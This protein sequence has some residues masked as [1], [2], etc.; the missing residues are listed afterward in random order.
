MFETP[1]RLRP[2]WFNGQLG[3][4]CYRRDPADGAFRLGA[5]NVLSLRD[6]LVTQL[7]SFIDP[8]LLPR[9]GLPADPP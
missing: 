6:G 7:S 4:A 5:V 1:W 8:E 9:L 2:A 3:F